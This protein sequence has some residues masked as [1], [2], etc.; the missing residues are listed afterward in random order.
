MGTGKV[1]PHF[2]FPATHKPAK[3]RVEACVSIHS[4]SRTIWLPVQPRATAMSSTLSSPDALVRRLR[5]PGI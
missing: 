1:E 4:L 2:N 5:F 3:E